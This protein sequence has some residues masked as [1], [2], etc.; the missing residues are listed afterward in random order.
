MTPYL[1]RAAVRAIRRSYGQR[2][3]EWQL[4]HSSANRTWKDRRLLRTYF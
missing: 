1:D 3:L 2:S 4:L